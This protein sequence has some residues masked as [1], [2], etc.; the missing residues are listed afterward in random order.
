MEKR[1]SDLPCAYCGIDFQTEAQ[2]ETEAPALLNIARRGRACSDPRQD[3]YAT[4][5]VAFARS[6]RCISPDPDELPRGRH[7]AQRRCVQLARTHGAAAQH[8]L[9]EAVRRGGPPRSAESSLPFGTTEGVEALARRASH[10]P[11]ESAS[12]G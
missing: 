7:S 11:R 2:Y 9:L 6:R 12:G 1:R 3:A 10:F 4:G 8:D 5:S